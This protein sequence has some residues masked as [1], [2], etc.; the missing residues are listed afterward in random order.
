[1]DWNILP[2][3]QFNNYIEQ[4][5]QLNVQ[6]A[7]DLPILHPVFISALLTYFAEGNEYLAIGTQ[8]NECVAMGFF[9]KSGTTTWQSFQPSQAPVGLWLCPPEKQIDALKSL[10][11]KLPGITLKI[12]ILQQDP[13]ILPVE[14][15]LN[16]NIESLNYITTG[17]LLIEGDFEGYFAGLGKNQRQNYNKAHNRLKKQGAD[18]RLVIEKSPDCMEKSVEEY[19]IIETA[20]WKNDLGTAININNQQ[21]QFYARIM[22]DFAQKNMAEV[23]KYFYDDQ[24]VAIDLCIKNTEQLI[25]LKTT[26]DSE[27]SRYSPAI[28]MKIDAIKNIYENHSVQRIEYFGKMLDWHKRLNSTGRT[29]YH[30]SYYYSRLL[31]ALKKTIRS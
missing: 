3:K 22:T 17:H 9:Y 28:N 6:L 31:L 16:S 14:S 30:F 20:S 8:N 2:A 7:R 23:W 19:G 5:Q 1:M 25:I 4:W 15:I 21:G 12:D 18:V 29:M 27:Y 10:A 26:F 24:L 13:N 11:Q